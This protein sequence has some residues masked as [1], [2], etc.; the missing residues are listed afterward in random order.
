MITLREEI[1]SCN[2]SLPKMSSFQLKKKI[3]RLA[4]TGKCDPYS[5]GEE[6]VVSKN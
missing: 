4:K 1:H 6:E 2:N 3:M 5:G